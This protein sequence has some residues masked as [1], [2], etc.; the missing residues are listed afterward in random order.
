VATWI[1]DGSLRQAI[2]ERLPDYMIPSAVVALAALPLT[3]SGKLNRAALPEP[4]RQHGDYLAPRTPKEELLCSLSSELLSIE[5]VGSNDNFFSIGGDSIVA[6]MLANRAAK[7][8][9]SF[10]PRDIFQN[11]T[12]AG[13]ADV[14]KFTAGATYTRAND[15]TAAQPTPIMHWLLERRGPIDRYCQ[16]ILLRVPLTLQESA[17]RSGLAAIV[18]THSALRVALVEEQGDW[19]LQIPAGTGQVS[20]HIDAGEF[21]EAALHSAEARLNVRSG[22]V[23]EAVWFPA[24]G[25]LLLVIHHI[26]VD[27]VSWRILMGDLAAASDAAPLPA[28]SMPFLGWAAQITQW[29]A[30]D[31]VKAELPYWEATVASDSPLFPSARLD[32]SRDTVSTKRRLDV[33]LSTSE[34]ESLL[35]ALPAAHRC[36]LEE[37][38]IAA[39]AVAARRERGI[40]DGLLIDL[41]SHGRDPLDEFSD[42][43]RSIG[44][45]TAMYPV[46]LAVQTDDLPVAVRDVKEQLRAVPSKG[47]GFGLLRYSRPDTRTILTTGA[48]AQIAWNYLGRIPQ[49]GIRDWELA[50][51]SPPRSSAD[52][53]LP[54]AHLIETDVAI[55]QQDSGAILT[56]SWQWAGEAI[57]AN[58]VCALAESWRSVLLQLIA[59]MG[60]TQESRYAPSDFPLVQLTQAEVSAVESTHPN[61]EDILPLSPLQDGLLF[62]LLYDSTSPDLYTVRVLVRMDGPLDSSRMRH[63]AERLIQRHGNLRVAIQSRGLDKPVQVVLRDPQLQWRHALGPDSFETL[64]SQDNAV[65]FAIS[66]GPLLRIGIA[67][68]D[69]QTHLLLLTAHH[70][71]LDGW[72]IPILFEELLR[73]YADAAPLAPARPYTHYLGYLQRQNQ[74]AAKSMWRQYLGDEPQPTL[75]SP[76][77]KSETTARMPERLETSF[78]EALTEGLTQLARAKGI[79]VSA[80]MQGIWAI[81]L[82]RFTGRK[83]VLFGITVSGRPADLQGVEAMVGLFINTLPLRIS[84][85]PERS[86]AALFEEIQLSQAAMLPFHQVSLA[87][88]QRQAGA[89]NLFDTLLVFE[90]YPLQP[91]A[92]LPANGLR[93]TGAEMRDATHYP[94]TVVLLPG[95]RLHVRMDYDPSAFN[96]PFVEQLLSGMKHLATIAVQAPET[97]IHRCSLL[98]PSERQQLLAGYNGEQHSYSES[99]LVALFEEQAARTPDR[100]AL[101]CGGQHRSYRELNDRANQLAHHLITMGAGP[102]VVVGI[103]LERSLE[104]IV[105]LLGVLKAGAAYLPIDPEYPDARIQ[106]MVADTKPLCVITSQWLAAASEAIATNNSDNPASRLL[107]DSAA[108]VIYTSGSTGNPKGVVVTHQNA[109]RLFAATRDWFSFDE[110]DVWALFHSFAFDFSVWEIWGPLLHGGRLVIVPKLVSRSPKEFLDLLT[111]EQVTVLNQTPSAFYQLVQSYAGNS[112]NLALR[113][114]VFGGEA[115]EFRRLEDWYRLQ[116]GPGPQLINMYGITET[117]VHVTFQPLDA[118]RVR[119]G[120]GSQIGCNIPDLRI[121]VLD[122]NLEPVPTGVIGEMYVAGAGLARGYLHA[123]ALTAERFVADPHGPAGTRMY[124][125]GDLARRQP[126]GNLEYLGRIDQQVK[127]RGFRIELGEIEAALLAQPEVAQAAVIAKDST[128]GGKRLIAYVVPAVATWIDDGSLRQAI[129][130]R[131]PDYMIPS[132]ILVIPDL[133]L[134][135]HGKLDRR[136]LPEPQAKAHTARVEPRDSDEEMIARIWSEVLE[137]PEVGITENFFELGGQ[138]L[139]ATQVISRINDRCGVSFDL[140][141]LFEQPTV[142]GLATAVKTQR[143]TP[144]AAIPSPRIRRARR[145]S[146]QISLQADGEISG[147]VPIGVGN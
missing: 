112:V 27:G 65:Q 134:T 77:G 34:T 116:N 20:L 60:S 121:Y 110:T 3:T 107:P 91:G 63:A 132:A 98:Q 42:P 72:S 31:A 125:T 41:E 17:L 1:D 29:A 86:I 26:A 49:S 43:T 24:A 123:P 74:A 15:T 119:N 70:I 95:E 101:T 54:L 102:E 115:L 38:L 127:I 44:W 106:S 96:R 56:A 9:L 25:R 18:R 126:D 11:P 128:H 130:E 105:A 140:R 85:R 84:L 75:L 143:S 28:E 142:Q 52:E 129:S 120:A 94:L 89:G 14:A 48:K 62:H 23:F 47:L 73:L 58:S 59:H 139:L 138:S 93:V 66:T 108:Y 141:V 137:I 124:R 2:S 21:T 6:I 131:L 103:C 8:G 82:A 39:L 111:A 78:P 64:Q 53:A 83:E 68:R 30:S 118:D 79:T 114:I 122:E 36:S 90:N 16:S 45:F 40:T 67:S 10:S 81:L 97:P 146:G 147:E 22:N 13:L 50:P 5:R 104:M 33:S 136:A 144:A 109:V 69:H 100:I 37:I 57:N 61:L 99:T 32:R 4:E 76:K 46:H 55:Q 80:V 35:S 7:A 51:E 71:L 135:V 133:P 19:K 87:E 88:I 117:T 145:T 92:F 12:M 113:Y